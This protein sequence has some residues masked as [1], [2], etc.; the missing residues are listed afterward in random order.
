[1][2]K[3]LYNNLFNF[4]S[5]YMSLMLPTNLYNLRKNG[6]SYL[7]KDKRNHVSYVRFVFSLRV[8]VNKNEINRLK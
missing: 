3:N 6:L 5:F 8:S 1:M 4:F 2:K 7:G